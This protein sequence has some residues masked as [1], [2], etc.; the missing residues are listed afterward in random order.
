MRQLVL[1]SLFVFCSLASGAQIT[2]SGKVLDITKINYVEYV[3]VVSTGGMFAIT[4]SMGRYSIL[5]RETDSLTFWYNNKPTQSFAV[6]SIPDP[7][8][9]DISLRIPVKARYSMLKE[10][11]VYAKSHRQDSLEN[12]KEYADIFEYK[13]PGLSTSITPGGGVGA[14]V[15]ELINIF[16]FKRNKR[17][18]SFQNRLEQQEQDKYVDYRFNKL[19]IRRLTSLSGNELDSF[20]RWYRPT[21]DFTAASDE[22]SFNQYILN[23]FYHYKKTVPASPAKKE[24]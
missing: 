17:L 14:D 16:R 7:N 9:F 10:V 6:S 20:M 24:D 19:L 8:E 2:I 3:R 18:K 11:T 22:V 12:R 4:D 15:N 5:V 21:Y 13:K 1:I 23:A